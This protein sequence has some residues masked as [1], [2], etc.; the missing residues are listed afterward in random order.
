MTWAATDDGATIGTHGPE[1]GIIERDEEHPVGAR[2]TLDRGGPNA[3]VAIT[4]GIYGWMFHTRFLSTADEGN[5]E[6]DAMKAGLAD[7]LA[8]IPFQG[9][10]DAEAKCNRVCEV[11]Q[12]FVARF[13]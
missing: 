5:R 8:L 10:P 12:E 2:I 13:P 4:C 11:I 1:D 3:P 7:I 6:F 9:D